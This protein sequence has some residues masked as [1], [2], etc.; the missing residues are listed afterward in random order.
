MDAIKLT[1]IFKTLNEFLAF[2]GI[3]ES[4]LS[5]YTQERLEE[6]T[7]VHIFEP[8]KPTKTVLLIH[9]YFDHSGSFKNVI[10][11][12]L[13]LNYRVVSYDL[14]GH[15]LSNGNRGEI[16]DFD[17]YVQEFRKVLA[18]VKGIIIILQ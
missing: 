7:N 12:F 1:D 18:F 17:D 10:N 16:H 4:K 6:K 2:Y 8:P 5:S 3:D 11:Y 15:G 14:E 13:S 9:G